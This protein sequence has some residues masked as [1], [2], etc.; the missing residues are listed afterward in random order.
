[1]LHCNYGAPGDVELQHRRSPAMLHRKSGGPQLQHPATCLKHSRAPAARCCATP[2]L[3]LPDAACAP[4]GDRLATPSSSTAPVAATTQPCGISRRRPHHAHH[5]PPRSNGLSSNDNHHG[6]ATP[7]I[8]AAAP[9]A[10]GKHR[11]MLRR[12]CFITTS[13][14]CVST[15]PPAASRQQ[16]WCLAVRPC[17]WQQPCGGAV[18]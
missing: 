14:C 3:S 18:I 4:S 12:E 8:A 9:P 2:L 7:L 16:R 5:R 10:V 11:R 1:M 13:M 15:W 6:A 17:A